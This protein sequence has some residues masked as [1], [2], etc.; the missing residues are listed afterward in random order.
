MISYLIKQLQLFSVRSIVSFPGTTAARA[1]L[2]PYLFS[3]TNIK[4]KKNKNKVKTRKTK[5]KIFT[6]E[7]IMFR[8]LSGRFMLCFG[9]DSVLPRF[10]SVFVLNFGLT[11]GFISTPLSFKEKFVNSVS[12]RPL[13]WV[14]DV[15]ENMSLQL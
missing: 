1:Q 10:A 7:Q 15:W 4:K 5:K 13:C 6:L 11:S 3:R 8:S 9:Y 14:T 2:L 12:Q